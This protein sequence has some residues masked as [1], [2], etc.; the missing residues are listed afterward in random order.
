M[1]RSCR[2][3]NSGSGDS[4]DHE[5]VGDDGDDKEVGD[6]GVNPGEGEEAKA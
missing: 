4:G 1:R 2:S 5:E 6:N 3:W